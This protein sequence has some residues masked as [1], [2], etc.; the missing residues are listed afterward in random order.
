MPF[1]FFHPCRLPMY[2]HQS[3]E[4][5]GGSEVPVPMDHLW[6]QCDG[7]KDSTGSSLMGEDA[8]A[9]YFDL[10]FS[11]SADFISEL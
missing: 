10:L 3:L 8:N 5:V 4:A 9:I 1:I 6:L 2:H 7:N 11:T